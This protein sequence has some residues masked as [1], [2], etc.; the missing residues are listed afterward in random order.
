MRRLRPSTQ[1]ASGTG[2]SLKVFFK[3][4][5]Y[6]L[7]ER[8][9]EHLDILG[10]YLLENQS[11][12]ISLEGHTDRRGERD[13]NQELSQKRAESAKAYLVDKYGVQPER[14]V[15]AGHGYDQLAESAKPFDPVN[16]RVEVIKIKE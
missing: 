8:A 10:A 5:S 7:S 4:D 12:E 13:Y 11:T 14:I 1:G 15:T 3:V 2:L 16:R 6:D 9:Q